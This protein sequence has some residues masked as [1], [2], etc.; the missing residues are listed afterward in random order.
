MIETVWYHLLIFF[1]PYVTDPSNEFCLSRTVQVV[2]FDERL[3]LVDV[4]FSPFQMQLSFERNEPILADCNKL[5]K[6]GG[7]KWGFIPFDFNL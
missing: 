6:R 4:P 3:F 7:I 1:T 5:V 2:A